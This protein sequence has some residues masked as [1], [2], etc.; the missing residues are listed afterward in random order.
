MA[1]LAEH[2]ISTHPIL[3]IVTLSILPASSSLLDGGATVVNETDQFL[4]PGAFRL[5][6][7][8]RAIHT[9]VLTGRASGDN[10][11]G[12]MGTAHVRGSPHGLESSLRWVQL[13]ALLTCLQPFSA[14]QGGVTAAGPHPG[15]QAGASLTPGLV[16]QTW[17]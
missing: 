16:C 12:S 11:P 9:R 6:D 1:C 5:S 15:A 7:M 10:C 14:F 3:P 8:H 4:P 13:P 2:R 17:S